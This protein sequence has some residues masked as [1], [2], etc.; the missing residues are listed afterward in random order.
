ML[1]PLKRILKRNKR[2][3]HATDDGA[4][5]AIAVLMVKVMDMDGRL[6]A[7]EQAEIKALLQQR[8]ALSDK[9]ILALMDRAAHA[10]KTANDLH[11]FTSRIIREHPHATRAAIIEEL[12]RVALADGRADPYE[13]QLIRRIADLIGVEHR[14][15]IEAKIQA[16]GETP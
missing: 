4:A 8:F 13:E 15:F 2:Q 9:E 5:L 3:D 16:R 6:D 7:A 14:D 12:W 1:S 11:Q 10:S